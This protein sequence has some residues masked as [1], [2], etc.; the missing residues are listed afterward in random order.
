MS[1]KIARMVLLELRNGGSCERDERCGLSGREIE[2][3]KGLDRDETHREVASH[4][5]ISPQTVRTHIKNIYKK[6]H[7]R[8]KA[9]ALRHYKQGRSL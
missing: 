7:A 5:G 2:I 8:N 6:L 4:L 9:E 3:L 1:P